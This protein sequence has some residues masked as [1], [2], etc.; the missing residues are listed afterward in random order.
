MKV[1]ENKGVGLTGFVI[2]ILVILLILAAGGCVY[3]LNNPIKENVLVK[4]SEDN[5]KNTNYI[6][7]KLNTYEEVDTITKAALE[8][9]ISKFY[10]IKNFERITEE[11]I[12][13]IMCYAILDNPSKSL[14]WDGEKESLADEKILKEL[15]SERIQYS[16][17]SLPNSETFIKGDSLSATDYIIQW[18][19]QDGDVEQFVGYITEVTDIKDVGENK[20]EITALQVAYNLARGVEE[21]EG[22]LILYLPSDQSE[23]IITSKIS[24]EDIK[25]YKANNGKKCVEEAKIFTEKN[26]IGYRIFTVELLENDNNSYH[27][28]FKLIS[29]K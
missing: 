15:V 19:F 27:G 10:Y 4:S 1:K 3:L 28:N 21:K 25:L 9:Y 11:N 29:I 23:K 12:D 13:S 14:V 16:K 17:D 24:E 20:F 5:I 26:D 2:T 18:P 6:D 8:K 7:E 22:D